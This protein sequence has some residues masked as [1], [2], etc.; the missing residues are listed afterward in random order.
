[1]RGGCAS[2]VFVG[3]PG[4]ELKAEAVEE[5][6]GNVGLLPVGVYILPIRSHYQ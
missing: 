2:V 6:V 3:G 5:R 1:M 4:K